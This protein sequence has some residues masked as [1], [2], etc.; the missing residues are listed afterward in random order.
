MVKNTNHFK[1]LLKKELSVLE[2][3]L[4]TVGR[5]NPDNPLDW[6]ATEKNNGADS[7]DELEVAGSMEEYET[8][9]AIL[10]QLEIR[11][12][13]VK[14]ALSKIEDGTYGICEVCG[15]EIELD[16]LEAN[17]PSTTCKLHMGE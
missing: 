7:A 6:E 5:K 4:K 1:E 9:R 10:N 11:L 2:G 17:P 3:E 8:N 13:N 16:R 15:N 14:K 12:N